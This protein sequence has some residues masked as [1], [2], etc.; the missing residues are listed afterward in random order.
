MNFPSG[1]VDLARVAGRVRRPGRGGVA[2]GVRCHGADGGPPRTR[3]PLSLSFLGCHGQTRT[4][5][6]TRT[7]VSGGI[8][9]SKTCSSKLEIPT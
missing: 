4:G 3:S 9:T 1:R 2:A 8:V 6:V 7:I 5:T